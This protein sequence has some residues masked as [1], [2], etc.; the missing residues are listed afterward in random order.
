MG[1]GVYLYR[2]TGDG[3]QAT[4]SM[5]LIDGQAGISSG[6]DGPAGPGGE[7]GAGMDGEK[8]QLYGLTIS[9]PGLVPYVDPAFRVEKGMH[10]LDLVVEAPGSDPSAKAASSGGILG[11]VDNTGEV[12]FSDALLVALY[13]LDASEAMPNNGDI[14]LG[15]VN[16]DGQVALSD[17]WAIVAWL[18]DPSDPS[19]PAGIGEP[20]GGATASLS[21]DPSTVSFSD[22]AVWHRF[23]VQAGEPVSVVVN[24]EGA[25]RSLEITTRS[26]RGSYCPAEADDDATRQDGQTLYL[27]GC[28]TG[29]ASVELR[30]DSDD[31]VLRTYTIEVSG[32]PA[33]LVVESP[34]VSDS[35]LTLTPGQT[36][37]F[38]ATVRN[39][40]T[41]GADATTL[42]YYRS[43]NRTIST[44]D[45]QVG[46]DAVSA[47][48]ADSTSAESISL[49]APSNAGT[50]YYGACVVSVAGESAG[51]NCSAGVRVRIVG[52][53]SLDL[54]VQSVSVS[55]STL[56]LTPGQSFTFNATVGNQGSAGAAATTLRYYRSSNRTI[57]TR[58]T[59]V[60]TDAVSALAADST[61]AESISLTAPSNAGTYYYGACVVS[62]A[63]ES[64]DNNC[65]AGVRV[66]VEAGSPD[67]IVEWTW[68]DSTM[69]TGQS[70]TSRATV[71]NQGTAAAPATTLRYYRS[72]D[73]TISTQDTEVGTDP[74]DA[75]AADGTS[76]ESISLTAPSSEGVYF[77]GACVAPVVGESS[78]QNNCSG[79]YFVYVWS[80][81]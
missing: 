22:D 81:G 16:A 10:P 5:L 73:Q 53:G 12:D 45:T 13:S 17:A 41:A 80:D 43:T 2:L 29:P 32:S 76:A 74:V 26:G 68:M 75:L 46:T 25:T 35:T 56:T 14:S 18:N 67:L 49:T 7:A 33:D 15:D 24:P 23:T 63:G 69:K 1:A 66:T 11:D 50:Y 52:A 55:D 37:T 34:S 62:V 39:Q 21:P 6:G 30:R 28:V 20:V 40:G 72:S 65:S 59:Q 61:S 70:F 19:L 79:G 57:S 54:V 3:V 9:G 27:S 4:R 78:T 48:A 8:A 31:T 64:A 38:N 58:D 51:N 71:R 42:R 60:G 36:F 47:L 44:R 77:Y